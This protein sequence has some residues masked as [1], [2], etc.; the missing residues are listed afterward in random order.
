M[1]EWM[2]PG[3]DP[4][5]SG[6]FDL[7]Y[8]HYNTYYLHNLSKNGSIPKR[9]CHF[10]IFYRAPAGTCARITQSNSSRSA[11]LAAR[12]TAGSGFSAVRS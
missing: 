12:T 9:Y 6:G 3:A 2:Y 4:A 10:F 7:R 5:L 8:H 11:S 1:G